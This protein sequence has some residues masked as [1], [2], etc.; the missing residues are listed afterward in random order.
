MF[1]PDPVDLEK[2]DFSGLAD[3]SRA[4]TN[5]QSIQRHN[6]VPCVLSKKVWSNSQT[7]MCR[8]LFPKQQ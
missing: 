7:W 5:E 6:R 3:P 2:L 1:A 8:S 4:D